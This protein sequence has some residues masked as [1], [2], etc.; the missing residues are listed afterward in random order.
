[1]QFQHFLT[2]RRL[3]QSVNILSNYC[4]EFPRFLKLCQLL[5]CLIGLRI[6]KHHLFFIKLIETFAFYMQMNFLNFPYF[7]RLSKPHTCPPLYPTAL[8]NPKINRSYFLT[9]CRSDNHFVLCAVIADTLFYRKAIPQYLYC[10]YQ[11]ILLRN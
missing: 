3:V 11:D 9:L 10:L 1:M 7:S 2:A 4:A 5:M 8:Q 6:Q